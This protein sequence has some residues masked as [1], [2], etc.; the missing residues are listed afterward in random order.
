MKIAVMGGTGFIG[1]HLVEMYARN[2]C[3][4]IVVSRSQQPSERPGVR[5]VTW[6]ELERSA[7]PLEGADA[8]VNLSG[9]SI[10]Q[11]WT[12]AA[13]E[14]ILNSRLTAADRVARL[15]DR[16]RDK[17]AV[18]VNASGISIYGTSETDVY[19]E[20]CPA[21]VV[22]FLSGVVE[23][24]ERAIDRIQGPR[25]VKLRVGIVLGTDG[26]AFPKMAL[27]YRLGVGGRIGTGRQWLSWIHIEDMVRV[28]DFCIRHDRI[29]GPVNATAPHPVT[30]DEF[31]RALGK[32]LRRPHLFPV[33][34]F[35][36][37]LLF[38]ELSVLLLEGQKVVPRTLI[39]HG[40]EFRYPTI[41][42]ALRQLIG[43]T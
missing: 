15:V 11:R 7:E 43:K 35:L 5:M 21:R 9:E 17:P 8:F 2:G 23:Q 1:G 27:P 42:Q 26:G 4:V 18:V 38:G 10:N 41:D 39:D 40:F 14:R 3:E 25:V 33:P 12:N 20:T 36:F 28:I 6:D 29:M 24:W 19:D 31:G 30:N 37:K 16:L 13:K 22:D 32:A 34:A